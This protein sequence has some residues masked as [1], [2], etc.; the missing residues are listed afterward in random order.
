MRLIALLMP[1]LAAGQIQQEFVYERAPFPE[2]HAS[3]IVE[4]GPKEFLAAWFGGSK[5]G[6]KDVAIWGARLKDGAWSAPVELAREK[7]ASTYNP[8]L[9]HAK[10]KTLWLYYKMGLSPDTWN[11][12]RMSSLDGGRTWSEKEYLPAGLYGPIKN[13]PLLLADGTIVSGTSVESDYAWSAWVERSVDLGNT[14]TKHGPVVYPDAPRGVIQPAIVPL[15][16]RLRMYLRATAAIGF[17]AYS[18]SKDGGRTWSGAKIT[19]LPNPNSGIDAVGLKDGR[20]VM[21]YNHTAKGRTPLN[22]AV[23]RDGDKWSEPIALETEPGEYSYPAII[24]AADGS[25]HATWTW[26][27]KKVKHAVIPLSALPK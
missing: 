19:N 10:N 4:T 2:C 17:I 13:K 24:Q 20:V 25:L 18:D 9:F 1:V 26:R 22:L 23:S 16:G 12:V 11:G 27:R 3:T 7:N 5:E 14:W 8:V 15:P 21:I 6:A